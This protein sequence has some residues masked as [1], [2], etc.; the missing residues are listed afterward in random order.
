VRSSNERGKDFK[1]RIQSLLLAG[2]IAACFAFAAVGCKD[3]EAKNYDCDEGVEILYDENCEMWCENDGSTIYLDTC[4]WWDDGAD[5]NFDDGLAEDICN[6]IRKILDD[7]NI[8][9]EEGELADEAQ[10]LIV[11]VPERFKLE[12]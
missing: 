4:S 8:K 1:M 12:D 6:E 3:D 7:N 5:E 2:I 9:D 11:W 10:D